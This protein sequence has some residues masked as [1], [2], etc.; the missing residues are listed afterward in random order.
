[1]RST[2]S[3]LR[4]NDLILTGFPPADA[5]LRSWVLSK[6]TDDQVTQ[7]AAQKRLYGFVYAL[8]TVTR[9]TLETIESQREVKGEM[10]GKEGVIDR[11]AKLASAFR[12]Y[13]TKGQSF[14]GPNAYRE[15]FYNKVIESANKVMFH[16][17]CLSSFL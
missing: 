3:F 2:H 14:K 4:A 10:T 16:V 1:M 6:D 5:T 9:T 11:Q 12:D 7:A 17:L 13:M 8:L 15:N